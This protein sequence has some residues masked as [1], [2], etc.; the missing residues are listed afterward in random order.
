M[1]FDHLRV[2]VSD[3]SIGLSPQELVKLGEKFFRA[4]H[5]LVQQQPGTDLDVSITR[6]LVELHGGLFLIE[7]EPGRGS[8]FSFTI[9]LARKE[10]S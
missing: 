5:D 3:T 8:T 10:A 7:S 4:K 9:P 6:N 1:P 2:S